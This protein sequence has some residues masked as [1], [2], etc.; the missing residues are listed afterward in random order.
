MDSKI[1]NRADPGSEAEP[2]QDLANPRP[3][4]GV[5]FLVSGRVLKPGKGAMPGL[6]S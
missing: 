5:W 4:A 6:R 2:G 1:W 3:R